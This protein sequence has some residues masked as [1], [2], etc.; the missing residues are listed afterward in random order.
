MHKVVLTEASIV[1]DPNTWLDADLLRRLWPT[2]WLPSQLR[3][4]WE[5][6]F[7]RTRHYPQQRDIAVDPRE[8]A[9]EAAQIEHRAA[10]FRTHTY[11]KS[12]ANASQIETSLAVMV[13][14][15]HRT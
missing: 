1:E 8:N 2:L 12:N 6:T 11:R 5:D 13:S 4:R 14:C 15:R 3:Q 10:A 7:P 9:P